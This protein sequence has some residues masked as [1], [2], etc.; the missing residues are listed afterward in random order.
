[1]NHA[2][3]QRGSSVRNMPAASLSSSTPSTSAGGASKT[4]SS[5]S[6][7]A[8]AASG[9][10]APSSTV[11]GS[12]GSACRRPG[13]ARLG[14]LRTAALV[15]LAPAAAQVRGRG[16]AREREVAPLERPR[17]PRR[18]RSEGSGAGRTICAPRSCH[19]LGD[20]ERLRREPLAEDERRALPDTASFSSA[21]SAIVGP[22]QRVC[23]SQT[24]VRTVTPGATT[25]VA[26]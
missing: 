16:G 20:G 13:T 12:S 4:S 15:E 2:R 7:S 17:R 18:C 24:F 19:P 21:M 1:M 14:G 8:A 3:R 6:A 23:S 22:S 9:L 11:G 10:C 25:L 5:D 26:S